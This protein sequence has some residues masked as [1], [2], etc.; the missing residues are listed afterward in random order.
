MTSKVFS[1]SEQ[2]RLES[3]FY[4]YLAHIYME[5][6]PEQNLLKQFS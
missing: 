6:N 4:D 3:D 2:S 1:S 5:K